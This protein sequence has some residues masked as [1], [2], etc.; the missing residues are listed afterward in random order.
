M[1]A[2]PVSRLSYDG[3]LQAVREGQCRAAP[4][5]RRTRGAGAGRRAHDGNSTESPEEADAII[6][7]IG[8]PAGHRVDRRGRHDRRWRQQHILVVDARTTPRW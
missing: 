6:A 5:R 1:C 8:A 4:R 7:E 3:R 2:A